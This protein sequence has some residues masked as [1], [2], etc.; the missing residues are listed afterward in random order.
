MSQKKKIENELKNSKLYPLGKDNFQ[1]KSISYA[2]KNK[3][4]EERNIFDPES[5]R[6]KNKNELCKLFHYERQGN[7]SKRSSKKQCRHIKADVK[8]FQQHF[9]HDT[10]E[11]RKISP[12]KEI[13]TVNDER[14]K[15]QKNEFLKSDPNFPFNEKSNNQSK[16]EGSA[17]TRGFYSAKKKKIECKTRKNSP[18]NYKITEIPT[19]YSSNQRKTLQIEKLQKS[20]KNLSSRKEQKCEISFDNNKYLDS[21]STDSIRS[22][23]SKTLKIKK[24]NISNQENVSINEKYSFG[25]ISN[26]ASKNGKNSVLNKKEKDLLETTP[27]NKYISSKKSDLK[28]EENQIITNRSCENS[29][30]NNK[31]C[32]FMNFIRKLIIDEDSKSKTMKMDS[33][34]KNKK[35]KKVFSCESSGYDSLKSVPNNNS[36]KEKISKTNFSN[37]SKTNESNNLNGGEKIS[38]YSGIE[39]FK[40][41]IQFQDLKNVSLY[42]IFRSS[43]GGIL[44]KESLSVEFNKSGYVIGKRISKQLDFSEKDQFLK[45]SS[46]KLRNSSTQTE[47]IERKKFSRKQNWFQR[48]N[49]I[50]K[51]KKRRGR[52]YATVFESSTTT[53]NSSVPETTDCEHFNPSLLLKKKSNFS[54]K[55][56]SPFKFTGD[57]NYTSN[58]LKIPENKIILLFNSSSEIEKK[59]LNFEEE[60]TKVNQEIQTIGTNL[61]VEK[62]KIDLSGKKDFY[63]NLTSVMVPISLLNLGNSEVPSKKEETNFNELLEVKEENCENMEKMKVGISPER[64]IIIGD[65]I[66]VK[67]K[68]SKTRFR[69]FKKKKK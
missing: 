56:F 54:E 19:N 47:I 61:L 59:L 60:K 32:Q 62:S 12:K 69:I 9:T 10:E 66:T 27:K 4:K 51:R 34:V 55:Y 49:Y 8:Y 57:F 26:D 38:K 20:K 5:K 14:I 37:F 13:T 40:E 45:N 17:R 6:K 41:N 63:T 67:K 22:F 35:T 29:N 3:H 7:D 28:N 18:N 24:Q 43:D 42:K 48:K 16:T 25:Q 64:K 33:S 23:D 36:T 53:S 65:Q 39:D 21:T 44:L 68:K 15:R 1:T 58:L 2:Q 46:C 31:T 30:H 50:N 52:K 11:K